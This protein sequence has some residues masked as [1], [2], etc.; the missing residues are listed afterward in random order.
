MEYADGGDLY[1]KIVE[2]QKKNTHFSEKELWN[3]F[4]QV[5]LTSLK[6]ISDCERIESSS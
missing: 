4:I 5:L 6:Y 2:H 3:I 1:N